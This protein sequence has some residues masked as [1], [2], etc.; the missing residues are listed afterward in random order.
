MVSDATK[1][2]AAGQLD[3][4]ALLT[5]LADLTENSLEQDRIWRAISQAI[6]DRS[7]LVDMARKHQLQDDEYASKAEVLATMR[8]FGLIILSYRGQV[9]TDDVIRSMRSDLQ[10]FEVHNP[11]T[12]PIAEKSP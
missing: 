3:V 8:Q 11:L 7:K 2:Q 4:N 10:R 5:R 6:A 9:L 1:E 12:A